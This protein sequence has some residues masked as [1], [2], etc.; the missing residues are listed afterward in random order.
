[1]IIIP[2]KPSINAAV[3]WNRITSPKTSTAKIVVNKGVV[4]PRAV[5][6]SKWIRPIALN[7]QI[8]EMIIIEALINWSL[9]L[10]DLSAL[11]LFLATKGVIIINP[12]KHR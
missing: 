4:K 6:F 7:H 3:L 10:L 2:I 1:M 9:V 5:A 12:I 8:I 11:K